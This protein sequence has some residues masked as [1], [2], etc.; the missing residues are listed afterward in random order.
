MAAIIITP[1]A[2]GN[3]DLHWVLQTFP[4]LKPAPTEAGST[5]PGGNGR[6]CPHQL[7]QQTGSM[8]LDHQNDRPLVE[9]E[10]PR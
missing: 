1:A 6:A 8:V 9:P 7:P 4:N 5:Q 3:S 2:S 10:M